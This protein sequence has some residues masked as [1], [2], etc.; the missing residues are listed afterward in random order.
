[1]PISKSNRTA[2]WVA[3]LTL[4]FAIATPTV[5]L[6]QGVVVGGDRTK[7]LG[8]SRMVTMRV[9]AGGTDAAQ[10]VVMIGMT[11]MTIIVIGTVTMVESTTA[12]TL[13]VRL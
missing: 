9:M 12:Q 1:M 13:H 8:N 2:L 6:A 5:S 11:M 4:I 7:K 10:V 3:I